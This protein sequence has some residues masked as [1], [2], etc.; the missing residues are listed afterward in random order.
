MQ[1][2]RGSPGRLLYLTLAPILA[3]KALE[4]YLLLAEKSSLE[5]CGIDGDQAAVP[6]L[7][8]ESLV[9]VTADG[10]ALVG[11]LAVNYGVPSQPVCQCSRDVWQESWRRIRNLEPRMVPG[12]RGASRRRAVASHLSGTLSMALVG[13]VHAASEDLCLRDLESWPPR[14][15]CCSSPNSATRPS[16]RSST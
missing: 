3:I 8:P 5:A 1:T 2:L 12:S 15:Y 10:D 13:A 6:G 4:A 14:F 16:W 9:L 11:D 7:P